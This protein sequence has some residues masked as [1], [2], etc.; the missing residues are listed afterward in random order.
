M[1]EDL[2]NWLAMI[3]LAQYLDVF[4]E[5]DVDLNNVVELSEDDLTELGLT[6][7]HRRTLQK[8]LKDLSAGGNE[9]S[10]PNPESAPSLAPWERHPDERKTATVL[11]ADIMGSTA[12]TEHLDA[13][14][15]HDLLDGARRR[16]CAA[17]VS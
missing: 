1:S 6:L 15:T 9:A 10:S 5:N 2:A 3:G 14:D 8:A 13:E 4:V 16:I 7:G 12:L 17:A 11:F